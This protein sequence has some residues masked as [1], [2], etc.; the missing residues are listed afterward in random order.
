MAI[1]AGPMGE[2]MAGLIGGLT[3]PLAYDFFRHALVV[4]AI[5]GILCPVVGCFPLVLRISLIGDAIAHAVIPG[6][7]IAHVLGIDLSVG[8]FVSGV[9]STAAIAWIQEQGRI[10][11]DSA[12]TL[13][14]ATFFALG[15]TLISLWRVPIDLEGFLFGD[16]LSVQPSDIGHAAIA[17]AVLLGAIALHYKELLFYTFDPIGAE[18]AGLPVRLLH[19]GLM[20][21][22]TV[23]II[24]ALK[25]VGVVLAVALT[26][27]PALTA[28]LLVRELHW[29]MVLGGLFG[30]LAAILGLYGS[31]YLDL[32]SGA[33]IALASFGLFMGTLAVETVARSR[34]RQS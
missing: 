9:G 32:P 1:A 6:L 5:I 22:L 3:D 15:M 18:A 34:F 7:A 16:L 19:Y 17:A 33:A 4:G 11:A 23:A 12:M 20:A 10:R 13:M 24:L 8:A 30:L 25:L 29:M 31:F 27:G 14:F 28:S 2:L 26:I 21:G